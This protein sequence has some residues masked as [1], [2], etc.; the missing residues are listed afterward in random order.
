ML[1]EYAYYALEFLNLA[2]LDKSTAI[3]GLNR[4]D[5]YAEN[6]PIPPLREQQR[7]VAAIDE[8]FTRLDAGVAS[9]K[10]ARANLKRYHAAVLKAA[11]EGCLVPQDPNDEPA[12]VLLKRILRQRRAAWAADLR[13][14][15][16]DPDKAKYPT[17]KP[18]DTAELPVLPPGWC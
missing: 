16:K 11:C 14:K 15:G 8:Q 5:A 12:S 10:R 9:L 18:P 3:P 13:K 6:I 17:P 7:I 2:S 4:N 1:L